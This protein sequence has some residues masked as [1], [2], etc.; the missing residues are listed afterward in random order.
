MPRQS[1]LVITTFPQ[2]SRPA[3]GDVAFEHPA[4]QWDTR[5]LVIHLG[6]SVH[7][8]LSPAHLTTSH[9]HTMVKRILP[10]HLPYVRIVPW[11]P[12]LLDDW[13]PCDLQRSG[14]VSEGPAIPRRQWLKGLEV[15]LRHIHSRP[16][17]CCRERANIRAW[18]RF[19]P[20]IL[21]H[22]TS[23]LTASKNVKIPTLLF[24]V[25]QKAQRITM[26][27]QPIHSTGRGGELMPS[28]RQFRAQEY[29]LTNPRRW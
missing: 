14:F 26:S 23:L 25:L 13:Q 1:L 28:S 7:P 18:C 3:I 22:L 10:G 17:A 2:L 20:A 5:R 15:R 6:E 16:V 9:N 12:L 21:V 19:S 11:P 27:T 4:Q 8:A 29:S 24:K